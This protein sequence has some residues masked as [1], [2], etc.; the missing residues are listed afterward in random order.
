MD[1]VTRNFLPLDLGPLISLGDIPEIFLLLIKSTNSC[2]LSNSMIEQ[3][4]ALSERSRKLAL[5]LLIST[6]VPDLFKTKKPIFI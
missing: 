3:P 5:E 2:D 6:T 1:V 4:T